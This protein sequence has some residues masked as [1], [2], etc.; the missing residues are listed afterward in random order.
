MEI[1]EE[2]C[3]LL[4]IV[5]G[6]AHVERPGRSLTLGPGE[7][8]GEIEVLDPGGGRI[9]DIHAVGAVRA[10]GVSREQLLAGAR[11]GPPGSAGADRG[12]RDALPRDGLANGVGAR[13]TARCCRRP[14]ACGLVDRARSALPE[15]PRPV[16]RRD[17]LGCMGAHVVQPRPRAARRSRRVRPSRRKAP[18]GLRDRKHRCS[19]APRWPAASRPPSRCSSERVAYRPSARRSSVTAGTRVSPRAGSRAATSQRSGAWVAAGILGAALGPAGGILTAA[20]RLGV[21]LPR[22]G[23]ARAGRFSS[24]CAAWPVA[25]RACAPV[26]RRL[27]A[28]AAPPARRGRARRGALPRRAAPRR[29]VG[30]EPRRPVWSS[31]RSRSSRSWSDGCARRHSGPF[32]ASRAA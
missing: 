29:R 32:R 21:D 19:P 10:I 14:R 12:A 25:R 20:P 23:A 22:A 24:R 5:E 13:A 27:T 6:E 2:G 28:N 9:A 16:R 3:D 11:G 15:D 4:L 8:I 1:G 18:R 30:D 7:L 31:R 17:H 26:G